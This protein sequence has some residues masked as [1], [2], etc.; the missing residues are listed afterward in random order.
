MHNFQQLFG[1]LIAGLFLLAGCSTQTQV[2]RSPLTSPIVSPTIQPR[3]TLIDNVYNV[4]TRTLALPDGRVLPVRCSHAGADI[5]HCFATF[6]NDKIMDVSHDPVWSPDR[7]YATI[8]YEPFHDSPCRWFEVWDIARGEKLKEVGTYAHRWAPDQAHV[9]AFMQESQMIGVEP[10]FVLFD[11]EARTETYPEVCPNWFRW[12]ETASAEFVCRSLQVLADLSPASQ[13]SPPTPAPNLLSYDVFTTTSTFYFLGRQYPEE[14]IHKERPYCWAQFSNG[15][16]L[17]VSMDLRES[18]DHQYAIA[19][20][21][22]RNFSP[23]TS[24]E[25]WNVNTWKKVKAL[26][27]DSWYQWSPEGH[28]LLYAHGFPNSP[29]TLL[30]AATGEE[31]HLPTCPDWFVPNFDWPWIWA[32]ANCNQARR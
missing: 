7:R 16:K 19:C 11:A 31:I 25:L 8:C 15:N 17:E 20:I 9:I 32:R 26:P 1:I 22:S 28:N 27:W 30:N 2:F 29:L 18:T 5:P 6:P 4:Y 23:C 14:C 13:A 10:K 21:G 3:P 12:P 24:V